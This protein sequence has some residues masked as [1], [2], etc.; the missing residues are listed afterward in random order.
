MANMPDE[1][2]LARMMTAL[3]FEFERALHYHDEGYESHNDYGLPPQITR[4]V[5]IYSMFSA[6]AFFN[7]ADYTVPSTSSHLSPQD[8]PEVCHSKKG[9]A[10]T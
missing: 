2:V 10:S 3:D 9:S 6:D 5:C 8:V 1:T 4:S 7:P